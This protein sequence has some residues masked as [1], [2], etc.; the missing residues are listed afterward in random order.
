VE[1]EEVA[2]PQ[3][4]NNDGEKKSRIEMEGVGIWNRGTVVKEP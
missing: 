1:S 2:V 3:L 4:T